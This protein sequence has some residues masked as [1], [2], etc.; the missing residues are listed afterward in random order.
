MKL[1]H[2]LLSGVLTVALA[3]SVCAFD[4]P[5]AN[6]A[7]DAVALVDSMGMGWNLGNTFDS[8]AVS[9][10]VSKDPYVDT[11]VGFGNS[12][13]TTA[14][15][16][17]VAAAGF[18]TVRIPVT[19][20]ENMDSNGNLD[21]DYLNRIE[22]VANYCFDAGLKVIINMHHDGASSCAGDVSTSNAT[23][24]DVNGAWL[25]QGTSQKTK[26]KNV[27]TQIATHFA[28]YGQELSFAGWNEINWTH[29][30]NTEMGQAFVDAV[31]A[32]GGNNANRLLIIPANNTNCAAA[33][34]SG[35]TLPNDQAN[36]LAVEVHYYEPPVFCVAPTDSTWGYSSTWGSDSE[37]NALK[38]DINNLYQ[39]FAAKGVPV[40]IGECG[41]LTNANKDA[42]DTELFLNT[43]FSTCIGYDGICPILWD[44]GNCGDMQYVD[45]NSLK[46]YNSSIE[47]MFKSLTGVSTDTANSFT[48]DAD[49][50]HTAATGDNGE[51]WLIDIKPFRDIATITGVMIRATATATGKDPCFGITMGCNGYLTE[52]DEGKNYTW[53]MQQISYGATQESVQMLFDD[54]MNDGAFT[55]EGEDWKLCYDFLK[56]ES[57]WMSGVSDFEIESITVLFKNPVV[58]PD[59]VLNYGDPNYVAS[60]TTTTTTT[61]T[62]TTNTTTTEAQTVKLG[63]VNCDGNVKI[64]DVIL[65]NRFL[66]EDK[67]V[68]IS[69]QG[70]SNADIDGDGS[71]TAA[72]AVAILKLLAGL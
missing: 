10:W 19:W 59:E 47:T 40:I 39:K 25:W 44:S 38:N 17:L 31:R 50:I 69:T 3:S 32:V 6:A 20:M 62:S 4:I 30:V 13:T 23:Q 72:D 2:K 5:E 63:D 26:F 11:E 18:D 22:E 66:S 60:S 35:F 45:R 71:A 42:A 16:A 1:Y 64:G 56:F 49:L 8:A 61:T 53:M 12:K 54:G 9:G 29:S 7:T 57:W 15:I 58:I 48:Y 41:V 65:L 24:A 70:L 28:D 68:V 46:W 14:M 43:L 33:L 34:E 27:W 21:V 55:S 52:K 36:M 37:I 51:Y 67:A